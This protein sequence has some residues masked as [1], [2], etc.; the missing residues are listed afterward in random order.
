M[1]RSTRT[2]KHRLSLNVLKSEYMLI[3]SKVR[4]NELTSDPKI[5]IGGHRLI[6]ASSCN[7]IP[8]VYD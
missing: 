4:I 3:G 5:F 1:H 2:F 7:K 6:K 8:G